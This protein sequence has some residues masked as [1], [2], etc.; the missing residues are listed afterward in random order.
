MVKQLRTFV[1]SWIALLL[2]A[3]V[4]VASCSNGPQETHLERA[5]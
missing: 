2:V 3:L 5:L 1:A 4:V